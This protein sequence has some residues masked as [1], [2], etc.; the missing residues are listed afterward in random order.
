VFDNNQPYDPYQPSHPPA[1]STK[2][3]SFIETRHSPISTTM[4]APPS[5]VG[6]PSPMYQSP[7]QQPVFQQPP[8]TIP[9]QQPAATIPIQQF[10]Q[11]APVQQYQQ[12]PSPAANAVDPF[13]Y[14]H[15]AIANAQKACKHAMSCIQFDDIESAV[16]NLHKALEL[17]EPF[18]KK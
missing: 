10:Q 7:T 9:I 13:E 2:Q 6:T 1:S 15:Q 17:L 14:D 16:G 3:P 11:P 4:P 18:L 5:A 8:P 12:Q